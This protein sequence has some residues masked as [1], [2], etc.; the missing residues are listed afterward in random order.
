MSNSPEQPN[1]SNRISAHSDEIDLS[2]QE[3]PT[4]TEVV[5]ENY[6]TTLLEHSE[7]PTLTD[8]QYH[9]L[10]IQIAPKLE[11]LLHAKFAPQ[12]NALSA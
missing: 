10:A 11:S 12:F 9:Q 2:S 5:T 1:N 8:A 7:F 3:I 4:L 6:S